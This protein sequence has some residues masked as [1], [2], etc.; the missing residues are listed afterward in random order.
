MAPEP[1]G[2][3]ERLHRAVLQRL[4]LARLRRRLRRLVLRERRLERLR[5]LVLLRNLGDGSAVGGT[6]RRTGAAPD[7]R[8]YA[9]TYRRAVAA[10]D[11]NGGVVVDRVGVGV[12]KI[13]PYAA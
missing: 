11:V 5:R 2:L 9:R 6:D 7:A 3:P 4:S 8:A 12:R 13:K 1:G 10:P